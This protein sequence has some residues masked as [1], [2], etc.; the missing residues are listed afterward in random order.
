MALDASLTPTIRAL[1]QAVRGASDS[2]LLK[3]AAVVDAQPDRDQLDDLVAGM[4][5][6]LA[7][8]RPPRPLRFERLLFTPLDPLIVPPQRWRPDGAT[9]PISAIRPIAATVRQAMGPAAEA[10]EAMIAGRSTRHATVVQAAGAALWPA[11]A[12]ILAN[13]PAPLLWETSGLGLSAYQPLAQRVATI[14]AQA[15]AIA[16]LA[17]D[18]ANG[19]G[20]PPIEAIVGL[21]RAA[22]EADAESL[23]TML[24]ILLSRLPDSAALVVSV[25]AGVGSAEGTGRRALRHA[26]DAILREC[27]DGRMIE[28]RV[29]Q[30]SIADAAE[31]ARQMI[32]L[33]RALAEGKAPSE[34]V[35]RERA[36]AVRARLDQGCQARFSDSLTHEL[37]G[38]LAEVT[39]AEIA[40][41]ALEDVGRDLRALATEARTIGGGPVYDR[42]LRAA[43]DT[44]GQASLA[45]MDRVRLTEI[46]AGTDVAMKLLTEGR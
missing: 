46:I 43:A 18:Q 17:R 2:Q 33:L 11:A 37:L 1:G 40:V 34:R 36:R 10:I 25:A 23:Q 24:V 41:P 35:Q 44:V 14:L 22:T 38:S 21:L 5:P 7:R 29:E 27:E 30:A 6:R 45:L 13:P 19:F 3:I 28:T 15:T 31:H 8:L 12:R 32:G 16:T 26:A 39:D 20:D 9:V 42:L 4:R